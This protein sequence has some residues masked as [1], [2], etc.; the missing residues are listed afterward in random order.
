M[1]S[2]IVCAGEVLW[3]SLPDGLFLG[4][5]PF[6]V[7]CCLNALGCHALLASRIGEDTLGDEILRRMG[8]R[9]LDGRFMTRD[10]THPTGFAHVELDE[11]GETHFA[12]PNPSAWDFIP[13]SPELDEMASRCDALI[14]G[15]LAQRDAVSRRTIEHLR[16][17]ASLVVFD[18]NLR[19]PYD[20]KDV[21]EASLRDAHVAKFN[22]SELSQL[23]IWFEWKE[24]DPYILLKKLASLFDLQCACMTCGVRGALAWDGVSFYEHPGI[25]IDLADPVGAGDAFLA[26]LVSRLLFGDAM[27]ATLAIASACGA[28]VASQRGATPALDLEAIGRLA[29]RNPARP[30]EPA[31][32]Q[33]PTQS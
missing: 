11:D 30:I 20:R 32:T 7:A 3:D 23:A 27:P 6:N 8:A 15:S 31:T 18:L 21:V 5:A 29:E 4:G 28:Y 14:F 10:E 2:S 22:E 9:G 24:A 33:I 17:K 1:R 26:G 19:P 13:E 12:I 25:A 16:R